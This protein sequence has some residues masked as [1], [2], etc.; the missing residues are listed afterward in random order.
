MGVRLA[1]YQRSKVISEAHGQR[2]PYTNAWH[3]A[4][5]TLTYLLIYL[6]RTAYE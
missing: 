1:A 2:S 6:G 4:A 3:L 5:V